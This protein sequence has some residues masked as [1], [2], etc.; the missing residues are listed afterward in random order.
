VLALFIEVEGYQLNH[1]G[2]FNT[3][4]WLK[5]FPVL[6]GSNP[7]VEEAYLPLLKRDI[8]LVADEVKE[9]TRRALDAAVLRALDLPESLLDALYEEICSRAHGRILKA[10]RQPTKRGREEGEEA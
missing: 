6:G 10:R 8:R 1:G 3:V 2:I 5:N 4:E 9:P 7:E